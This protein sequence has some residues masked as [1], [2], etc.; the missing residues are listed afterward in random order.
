MDTATITIIGRMGRGAE[1]REVGVHRVAKFSL[2]CNTSWKKED[3]PSWFDCEAWNKTGDTIDKYGEKGKQVS[4]TGTPKI[5]TYVDKDGNNRKSFIITVTSL[6]LLGGR[7]EG[8]KPAPKPAPKSAPVGEV[9]Q[10][11]IPF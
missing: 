4:V 2:A 11:D 3:P 5:Q 7:E 8:S 6:Q 9:A 1:L 10:D